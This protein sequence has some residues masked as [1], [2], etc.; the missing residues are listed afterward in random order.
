MVD[1][2]PLAPDAS[3]TGPGGPSETFGRRRT[4]SLLLEW[5]QRDFR[6]QYRRS[7]LR[8]AWA[9]LSPAIS[10]AL[11]VFMFGVVFKLDSGDIPYVSFV[12]AGMVCLRFA[13]TALNSASCLVDN[14]HVLPNVYFPRAIIPLA[15]VLGV[16]PD[17]A[18]GAVAVVVVAWVQ[19]QQP[20]V[21]LVALVLPLLVLILYTVGFTVLFATV[22][23]F[24]RDLQFA[25]PFMSQG[26]FLGSL[27][28]YDAERLPEG[29]RWL[30]TVNPVASVATGVRDVTLEA[31]WPNWT[32]L[33]VHA[34]A[35]SSL[36]TFSLW[37]LRQVEH[38][39]VDSG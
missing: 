19:G 24:V 29:V 7:G 25:T 38:R 26:L 32:V 1:D 34:L 4:I 12:L 9:V 18:V 15:R 6:S 28:T 23:T 2:Q 3:A 8:T 21:H 39:I 16:L 22:T 11:V 33:A 10:I 35:A 37:H 36:L 30:A 5:A 13:V 20:T 17:L 14:A 27:I 31:S